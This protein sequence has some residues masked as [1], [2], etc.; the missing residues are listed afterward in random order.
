MKERKRR[1]KREGETV[2]GVADEKYMRKNIHLPCSHD[3]KHVAMKANSSVTQ[4]Q[5]LQG[6]NVV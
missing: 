6:K 2:K 1:K 3:M 5:L 4:S